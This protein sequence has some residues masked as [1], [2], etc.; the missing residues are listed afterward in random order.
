MMRYA[1]HRTTGLLL[2]DSCTTRTF[3]STL[4]KEAL[5]DQ[6]GYDGHLDLLDGWTCIDLSNDPNAEHWDYD[7]DEC[8]ACKELELEARQATPPA[9]ELIKGHA[10]RVTRDHGMG[11]VLCECGYE[12]VYFDLDDTLTEPL[13]AVVSLWALHCYTARRVE[14][15]LAKESRT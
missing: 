4:L 11:H 13:T 8:A 10:P 3:G 6:A 5:E 15:A 14:R 7:T 9:S 12:T 1:V 2:C